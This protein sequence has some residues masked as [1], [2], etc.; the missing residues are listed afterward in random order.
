M[1]SAGNA[2]VH[3][4]VDFTNV[5][6]FDF[7]IANLLSSD[8]I[9]EFSQNAQ[10]GWVIFVGRPDN[11]RLIGLIAATSAQAYNFRGRWYATIEEAID[12]LKDIDDSLLA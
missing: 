1:L 12:F 9:E 5:T 10:L 8:V 6:K 7:N 2:P 4:I 11:K 3:N